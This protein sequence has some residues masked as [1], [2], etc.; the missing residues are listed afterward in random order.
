MQIYRL[1]ETFAV[2]AQ[3]QPEDVAA[4]QQ[5]GYVAIVCNRP[6]DEDPGQPT[7]AAI[8]SEC[9][10]H[11]IAFHHLPI[12]HDGISAEMV[13]RFQKIVAQSAGAVLA[14]CRSGQ[15]SSVLWQN[16]GSP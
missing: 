14:Y 4:L 10:R 1:K 12:S 8:A 7:A 15:R 6:D 3:I 16:S 2:A 9:K 5:D 13:E 11:G